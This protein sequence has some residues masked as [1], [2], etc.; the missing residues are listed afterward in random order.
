MLPY[1]EGKI[2][3]ANK[4]DEKKDDDKDVKG[5]KDI[6]IQTF[7]NLVQLSPYIY[8]LRSTEQYK[9]SHLNGAKSIPDPMVYI[10]L[11]FI[12]CIYKYLFYTQKLDKFEEVLPYPIIAYGDDKSTTD[13]I[14]DHL[15]NLIQTVST[16]LSLYVFKGEYEKDIYAKFPFLCGDHIMKYPNMIIKDELFLGDGF[17]AENKDIMVN[18]KITHIVNVTR[19]DFHLRDDKD[20]EIEKKITYLK[21]PV[22]DTTMEADKMPDHFEKAAKFI[23][24][25]LINDNKEKKNRVFIHCMAGVSR[26]ASVV[27]SYLMKSRNYT[28]CDGYIHV[29]KCRSRIMPN[30][31]FLKRL[32]EFEKKVSGKSTEDELD[33]AL[34]AKLYAW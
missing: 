32:I 27:I 9:K 20:G 30:Q 6:D 22:D 19:M 23:D 24:D 25:A 34:K 28:L 10:L 21:L 8:D 18:L 31:G 15:F 17:M 5:P 16:D 13:E 26:S 12:I 14:K 29:K 4:I 1:A 3:E 2:E 11:V 7:F 33:K